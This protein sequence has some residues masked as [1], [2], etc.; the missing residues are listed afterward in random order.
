MSLNIEMNKNDLLE[1]YQKIYSNHHGIKNSSSRD[2]IKNQIS[3]FSSTSD[4][5]FFK[6]AIKKSIQLS[7]SHDNILLSP[8]CAS[9][10]QFK[11][12][13]ERGNSFKEIILEH[14]DA[15]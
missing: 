11:N 2:R 1:I 10:D 4:F 9:F 6:N 8:A 5:K 14:Y 3:S 12:Y 13:K 15:N 7:D